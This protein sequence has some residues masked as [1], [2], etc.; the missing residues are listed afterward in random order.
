MRRVLI[1]GAALA[2]LLL[3]GGCAAGTTGP[4]SAP[5]LG[6]PQVVTDGGLQD[7]PDGGS[8]PGGAPGV[9]RPDEDSAEERAVIVTGS[10][11][12]TADDPIAAARE[13]VRIAEAAGGRVDASS[14][15]APSGFG[16]GVARLTLR[17]PAAAL[18]GVLDELRALGRADSVTT[19]TVDVSVGRRDVEAR[20]GALKASIARLQGMMGEAGDLG[21]LLLLEEQLGTRQAELESLQ[22]YQRG[23]DDQVAMSTVQ[24]ELRAPA[25]AAE[26]APGSFLDG[27]LAGWGAF[28]AFWSWVLVALG[29][30]LPWLASAG[31]LVL[32]AV[33]LLRRRRRRPGPAEG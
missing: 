2:A 17:I 8:G 4:E 12:I 3:L 25:A 28:V 24:L 26:P 22:A 10:A 1:G 31:L 13:A 7:G 32:L 11:V 19:S 15:S 21:D 6:E 9:E 20:I 29:V 33:L 18:T 30:L 14:E 16:P 23:L 5:G 27:L